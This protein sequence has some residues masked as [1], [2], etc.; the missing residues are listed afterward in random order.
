M[1]DLYLDYESLPPLC[2]WE[3]GAQILAFRK[4]DRR[5]ENK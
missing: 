1:A 5:P 2:L 3:F 4:L